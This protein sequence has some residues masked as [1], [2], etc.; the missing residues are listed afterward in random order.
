MRKFV[1]VFNFQEE[2]TVSAKGATLA[3][4]G[5]VNP[6]GHL[7]LKGNLGS[8]APKAPRSGA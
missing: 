6:L 8:K 3:P 4:M 1:F 5:R 7:P 2:P